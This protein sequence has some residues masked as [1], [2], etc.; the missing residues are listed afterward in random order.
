MKIQENCIRNACLTNKHISCN[1]LLFFNRIIFIRIMKIQQNLLIDFFQNRSI[2][3]LLTKKT[4]L[5]F[6]SITLIS[7]DSALNPIFACVP[8][9][10]GLFSDAPHLHNA[11]IVLS[12]TSTI[13]GPFSFALIVTFVICPLVYCSH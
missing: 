11:D 8:S 13:S 10:L 3:I 1:N 5:M 6:Y 9:H 4:R 2:L 7:D 12:S